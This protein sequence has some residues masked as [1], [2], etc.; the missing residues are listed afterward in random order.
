MQ[1]LS[2]TR[3]VTGFTSAALSLTGAAGF[4][5]WLFNALETLLR[6]INLDTVPESW[7]VGISSLLAIFGAIGAWVAFGRSPAPTR[8]GGQRAGDLAD[9]SSDK[10]SG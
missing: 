1:H 7:A 4:I 10:A 5:A 6:S 3:K 8:R 9:P 2:T